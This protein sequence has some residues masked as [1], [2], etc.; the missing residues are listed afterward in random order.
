MSRVTV[1]IDD[2]QV[3]AAFK[4]G[5][6]SAGD[7]LEIEMPMA[8][9]VVNTQRMLVPVDTGATRASIKPDVQTATPLKVVDHIGPS[10]EYAPSI[11]F[12]VRSKPNYPIQPFVRP[13]A[14]G[15]A[16]KRVLKVGQAAYKALIE[17]KY[18]RA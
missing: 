12:G 4:K 15:A 2:R 16:K 3:Q 18:G 13:S 10:T 11:E 1:K 17:R 9:T 5:K 7:L 8:L 14:F 6:L